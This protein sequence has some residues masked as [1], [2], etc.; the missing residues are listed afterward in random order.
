MYLFISLIFHNI[1]IYLVRETIYIINF[2]NKMHLRNCN[3]K[4]I[5]YYV[6]AKMSG[7]RALTWIS[8]D[9]KH[10]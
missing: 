5:F 7:H 8:G 4:K 9:C 1:I 3:R 2:Y 10:K 6:L